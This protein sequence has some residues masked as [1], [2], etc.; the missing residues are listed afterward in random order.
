[1]HAT[2]FASAYNTS[3]KGNAVLTGMLWFK[4]RECLTVKTQHDRILSIYLA[5]T[6][7]KNI[8]TKWQ[9][10]WGQR[11]EQKF[12]YVINYSLVL[13]SRIHPF[14]Q[15]SFVLQQSSHFNGDKMHLKLSLITNLTMT[16]MCRNRKLFIT[17]QC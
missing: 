12:R 8:K 16:L 9:K 7:R 14:A 15:I 5:C 3:A 10:T 1:M 13:C 2:S 4:L 6:F 17:I 11:K